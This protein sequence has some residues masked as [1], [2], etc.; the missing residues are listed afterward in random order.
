VR[1]IPNQKEGD[2]ATFTFD[3][4]E[5]APYRISGISVDVQKSGPGD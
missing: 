1:H 2:E 5:K 4:E 3:F